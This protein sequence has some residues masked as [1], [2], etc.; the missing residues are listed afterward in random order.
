MKNNNLYNFLKKLKNV[1][2]SEADRADIRTSLSEHID[3]NK[4]VRSP[5]SQILSPLQSIGSSAMVAAMVLISL[6]GISM[7]AEDAV[8]GDRLYPVKINFNEEFMKLTSLTPLSKAE[9]QSEIASRRIAELETLAARGTLDGAVSDSL[10]QAISEHTELARERIA[11]IS[12]SGGT[13]NATSLETELL[14]TLNTHSEI[15]ADLSISSDGVRATTTASAAAKLRE[16]ARNKTKDDVSTSIARS[17]TVPTRSQDDNLSADQVNKLLERSVERLSEARSDLNKNYSQFNSTSTRQGVEKLLVS[18]ADKIDAAIDKIDK[19]TYAEATPLLREALTYAHE[20]SIVIDARRSLEA[21]SGIAIEDLLDNNNASSSSVIEEVIT[22]AGEQVASN[23]EKV[24]STT[25]REV[26]EKDDGVLDEE[27]TDVN[28]VQTASEMKKQQQEE[29]Q[30][31]TKDST[32]K[33]T[34]SATSTTATSSTSTTTASTTATSTEETTDN[35]K[36]RLD[37]NSEMYKKID[38]VLDRARQVLGV[39]SNQPRP[40]LLPGRTSNDGGEDENS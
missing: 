34:T 16:V 19:E 14:S 32:T 13:G 5:W 20:V 33:A 30:D 38:R 12:A 4:P 10:T 37:V 24:I 29:N 26:K 2:L 11:A 27:G 9:N 39:S 18:S 21:T 36:R 7:A 25:E 3:A 8:P 15:L 22:S 23:T 28:R 1:Q 35:L 17:R 31:N 6:G 40:G